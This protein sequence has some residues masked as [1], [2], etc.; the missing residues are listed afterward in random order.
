MTEHLGYGP[1]APGRRGTGD[2]RNGYSPKTAATEVGDIG[3]RPHV[4]P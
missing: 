3:L 2:R 1:H 4:T